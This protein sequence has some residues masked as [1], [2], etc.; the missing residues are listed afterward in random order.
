MRPG[1]AHPQ[2]FDE[3][4]RRIDGFL[5]R[6]GRIVRV[7]AIAAILGAIGYLVILPNWEAFGAT[8]I[9]GIYMLVQLGVM[10]LFAIVPFAAIFWF[11]G[12]PRIYW[13]MPGETGVS[14]RDYKGNPDVLDAARQVVTLVKGVKHFEAMG[15]QPIRGLLLVGQPGAGKTYLGQAIST[16]A[17]VPFGYLSAP[18]IMGMF[19]GMDMLRVLTMYG[20]ARRLARRYGACILFIDEI[21][22]I[23]RSRTSQGPGSGGGIGVSLGG[24]SGALNE[25]LNQLDPLPRD[26][27]R[28]RLLRRLGLR[29]G[30]AKEYP[31][32]TIAATNLA[33]VLDPALLR[34]GHFDRKI[35]IEPPDADGRRE[36]VEYYLCK[37][38]HEEMSVEHLVGD[39]IGYTPVLI[40]H[41]INEAV[42]RAHWE[43]REKISYQDIQRAIEGHEWGLRQ[44]IRGLSREEKRRLAYHEAGHAVAAAKLW[45]AHLRVSKA[46]IVR[47]GSSLGQIGSKPLKERHTTTRDELLS[48][49]Q[50]ALASR[51]AEQLY[52]GIELSASQH[53]L[54]GATIDADRIVRQFGMAGSLYQPSALGATLPVSEVPQIEKLL[55]EQFRLAKSLLTDH[56]DAVVAVA[57]A[58]LAR[59]EL[60]GD[61]VYALI[62]EADRAARRLG[63][64]GTGGGSAS[65][66]ALFPGFALNGN[67]KQN[68]HAP[69][70]GEPSPPLPAQAPAPVET[71]MHQPGPGSSSS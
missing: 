62:D 1:G 28:S 58:L 54:R 43:G 20:R 56:A 3:L 64:D 27:W 32:L 50:V 49:I 44:P 7:L 17:G 5:S 39:T 23:G 71:R 65:L 41:V 70:P 12:R 13:T 15:G 22:A 40:K 36:I 10:V 38:R 30:R 33:E 42:V 21:D 4:D 53:D 37:V 67:A 52:L 25:L 8:L 2:H 59:E 16:E 68:G 18:S 46:T 34:P 61:E 69:Q 57:E 51:A 45:P 66:K 19:W 63:G 48:R 47:H 55:D 60:Q 31:V 14:F 6:L 24:G 9:F 11:L 35:V 26:G 29:T